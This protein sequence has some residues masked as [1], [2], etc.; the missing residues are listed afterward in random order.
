MTSVSEGAI[1]TT[2][3]GA[4]SNT[5]S[6]PVLSFSVSGYTVSDEAAVSPELDAEGDD[7]DEAEALGEADSAAEG[8]GLDL[9]SLL[10][11]AARPN[12]SRAVANHNPIL[13]HIRLF[14]IT[15]HLSPISI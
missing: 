13:L 11:H 8:D 2:R 1:V 4:C 7:S 10:P 15:I 5:T 9:S 12:T 6:V 3:S 14:S